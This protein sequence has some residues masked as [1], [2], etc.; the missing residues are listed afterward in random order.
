MARQRRIRLGHEAYQEDEF[1]RGRADSEVC[2]GI[3]VSFVRHLY[4]LNDA[5]KCAKVAAPWKSKTNLNG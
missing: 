2:R 5:K 3:C 4:R 1:G